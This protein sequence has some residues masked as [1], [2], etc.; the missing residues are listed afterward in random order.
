[1]NTGRNEPCPCGSG[2]KT[3][4]CCGGRRRGRPWVGPALALLI[5]AIGA[6][7]VLGV[8]KRSEG[9]NILAGAAPLSQQASAATTTAVGQGTRVFPQ[10]STPAPPGKVWSP[11][12]GHWHNVAGPASQAPLRIETPNPAV[13]IETSNA[14]AGLHLSLPGA[15]GQAPKPGMVWSAEHGHWHYEGTGSISPI[16]DVRA[17]PA[18]PPPPL[19]QPPGPA[20]DGK[21]WSVEHGHWHD[22]P[23]P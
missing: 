3:K 7:A 13:K 11:E 12:H 5:L 15:P 2:K 21:V 22:A 19:A 1:M 6:V 9:S 20:P 4:H 16:T 18:G 23:K 10:P 14:P 17:F 8:M